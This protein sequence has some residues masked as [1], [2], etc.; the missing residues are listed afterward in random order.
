[1]SRVL[2]T[3]GL[4][5]GHETIFYF[6]GMMKVID[7]LTGERPLVHTGN[8][9]RDGEVFDINPL[10]LSADSSSMAAPYLRLRLFRNVPVIHLVRHPYCVLN[11]F[12]KP[13]PPIF[14]SSTPAFQG[15]ER[16]KW[17]SWIYGLLPVLS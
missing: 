4:H 13:F 15:E 8:S 3:L 10:K 14:K 9:L 2:T 5:C 17:L 12:V 7:R 1:M 11:S 16:G 6:D